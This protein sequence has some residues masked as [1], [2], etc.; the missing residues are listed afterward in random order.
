MPLF[1]L[2]VV[3]VAALRAALGDVEFRN[4]YVD[5]ARQSKALVYDAC[6]RLGL[7]YWQSAANFVLVDGG[8]RARELVDGL[9]A[10]GVFVRD[11][12]KDPACPNCFRLTTGVVEHTQAGGGGAG[13]PVRRAVID[14]ADGG[15]ADSRPARARRTR[16]VREPHRASAS[17]IT[18]W[19]SSRGT[20]GSISKSAPP[21]ISTSIS[22][23]PSRT[24]ASRSARR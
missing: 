1:N 4:W 23:T 7:R 11:R 13:G 15:D 9:I 21:A 12:T 3:A 19:I 2:N 8:A 22:I 14:R 5:Q 24:S 20:A 17:S 16:P 10:R 18:C 6:G